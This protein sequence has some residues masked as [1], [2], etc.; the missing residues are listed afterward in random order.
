MTMPAKF[1]LINSAKRRAK[2]CTF[3]TSTSLYP[4]R[5]PDHIGVVFACS[6]TFKNESL[7][8]HLLQGPDQ[9]NFLIGVLT[10]LR[11]EEVAFTCD[12]EKKVHSFYANPK[13]SYFLHFWGS[14]TTTSQSQLLNT[15]W[16]YTFNFWCSIFTWRRY[17]LPTLNRRNSQRRLRTFSQEIST[18][19]TV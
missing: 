4:P 15:E 18:W 3:P 8:K 1:L 10:R 6:A 11:K 2:Y 16:M 19:T 12:I 5:K 9:L 7:N 17:L 13:D 14:K